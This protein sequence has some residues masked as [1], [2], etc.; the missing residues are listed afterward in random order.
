MN[1]D[2][3]VGGRVRP[4]HNIEDRHSHR[5]SELLGGQSVSAANHPGQDTERGG[6]GMPRLNDRGHHI[7]VQRITN[8]TG[9]L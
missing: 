5:W 9:L 8:C 1:T 7:L 2:R 4:F 6:A 3:E